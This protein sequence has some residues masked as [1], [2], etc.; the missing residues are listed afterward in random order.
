VDNF[1]RATEV[2][3][4]AHDL[5]GQETGAVERK[6]SA[7]MRAIHAN[8]WRRH[9]QESQNNPM[10]WERQ[11]TGIVCEG[12]GE[13]EKIASGLSPFGSVSICSINVRS[14]LLI[15]SRVLKC[16]GAVHVAA[17]SAISSF[18]GPPSFSLPV[19]SL[20][21]EVPLRSTWQRSSAYRM[22]SALS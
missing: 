12:H 17:A 16:A 18:T 21:A 10:N 15:H 2:K 9:A 5:E 8:L 4:H 19:R 7:S 11:F 6:A 22:G 20:A 14:P 1:S 3:R 13:I